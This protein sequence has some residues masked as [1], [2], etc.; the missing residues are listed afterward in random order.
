MNRLFQ[1]IVLS[2]AALFAADPPYHWYYYTV[3]TG[4]TLRGFSEPAF[5]KNGDLRVAYRRYYQVWH[6][7]LKGNEFKIE[8]ADTG[9]GANAKIAFAI[10][11]DNHSRILYHDDVYQYVYLA[12]HDGTKWNHKTIDA[13]KNGTVDFYHIDMA[14]NPD[15]NL[16]FVYTKRRP[17]ADNSI[18]YSRLDPDGTVKDSG[19]IT[20]GLN[21]KWN[22]VTLDK[23]GKPIVTFFRHFG[24]SL[25]LAYPT[26]TARFAIQEVGEGKE[27]R[28][29]GFYNSIKRDTGNYFYA[30]SQDK[31]ED[32][33]VLSHGTPGGEWTRETVDTAIGFSLFHSPSMLGLG[34]NNQ[35]FISYVFIDAPLEDSIVGCKL[36]LAR[37]EGDEWVKEVVDS[38]GIVGEYASLAVSADGLPAISYYDRT[39]KRIRVALARK[40]A[41]TDTN[42]NGVPDYQEPAPIRNGLGRPGSRIQKARTSSNRYDSR[43]KTLPNRST[44]NP[45]QGVYFV[46]PAAKP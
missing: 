40:E 20:D 31:N 35:P 10:D 41:P 17:N 11:K 23:D 45:A 33:L 28:P 46:P 21:G 27:D 13:L 2:A 36:M 34:K 6:G 38:T 39:N 32:R 26:D 43:G 9:T 25:V 18:V 44:A 16:H 37:K 29:E 12:S 14:A 15:G 19:F 4:A 7:E 5:D 3:D 30:A 24:E 22:S 1:L 42:S 8:Q